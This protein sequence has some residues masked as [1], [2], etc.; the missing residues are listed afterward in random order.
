MQLMRP[1][2][3]VLCKAQSGRTLFG[4]IL[5]AFGGP[6]GAGASAGGAGAGDAGG[7]AQVSAIHRRFFDDTAGEAAAR[8]LSVRALPADLGAKYLALAALNALVK[9]RTRARWFAVRQAGRR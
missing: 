1:V 6:A 5:A 7:S 9:V 4:K 8:A 3:V 2:D